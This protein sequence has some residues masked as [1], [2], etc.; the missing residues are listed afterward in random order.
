M[1]HYIVMQGLTYEED[2]EAGLIWSSQQDKGGKTPHSWARVKEVKQDDR[3]F[4]CVKGKIVAI[5]VA[6]SDSE[7]AVNPVGTTEEQGVLVKL[8]YFELERPL[9]IKKYFNEL[10]T[11]LPVKYA[12]FK[13]NGDGNQGYLYPCNEELAIKFLHIISDT[14]IYQVE[15]E[16]LELAIGTVVHTERNSLIPV[17]TETEA[18][19]R[20][21]MRVANE[22][23]KALVAPYWNHKCALCG[24]ELPELLRASHAKPWRE[25]TSK[26]RLDPYNGL[27][28]CRNHDALYKQGYIAFDGTGLIHISDRIPSM[29]YAMYDIHAKMRV[30]RTE[31]NKP[32]FRWHRKYV[33]Q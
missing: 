14:N 13:Q 15:E 24:I 19:A 23:F 12:A 18:A 9:T 26:E 7:K 22:K 11:L 30:L 29:N 16:Q 1:N 3:I 6:T 27:L 2:K 17:I 31:N 21:K 8:Q 5:S 4:H 25:C 28:L 10:R 32:Y 20:R 33:F